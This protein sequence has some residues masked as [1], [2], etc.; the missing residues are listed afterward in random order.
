MARKKTL[1]ILHCATSYDEA[2]RALAKV[3][4]KEEKDY[5]FAEA[6]YWTTRIAH[7]VGEATDEELAAADKKADDLYEV[8]REK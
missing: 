7:A 1:S 6:N 2:L 8:S 3:T 5:W 4:K